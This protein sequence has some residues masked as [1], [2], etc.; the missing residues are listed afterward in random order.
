[1][2][3]P[4]PPPLL[5]E[6]TKAK[7]LGRT[8]TSS[9]PLTGRKRERKKTTI[10]PEKYGGESEEWA[11]FRA[12]RGWRGGGRGGGKGGKSLID[13]STPMTNVQPFRVVTQNIQIYTKYIQIM[14]TYLNIKN[15]YICIKKSAVRVYMQQ[16]HQMSTGSI[17]RS[18]SFFYE[19]LLLGVEWDRDILHSVAAEWRQE[20]NHMPDCMRLL[21]RLLPSEIEIDNSL[22]RLAMSP[23]LCTGYC[24]LAQIPDINRAAFKI[25]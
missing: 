14:Q 3:P 21:S 12:P 23:R 7:P 6:E 24:S 8:S 9:A 17:H 22:G 11:E 4:S 25:I 13:I 20:R 10:M 5:T 19:T 15:T 18:D 1:M 16:F 2:C